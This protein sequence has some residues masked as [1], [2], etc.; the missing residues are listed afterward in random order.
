MEDQN[1]AKQRFSFKQFFSDTKTILLH[2][3]EYF[4]GMPL[5]GG[6][7]EPIVKALIYGFL[8]GVIF[9]IWTSVLNSMGIDFGVSWL[10]RYYLITAP[11]VFT[12]PAFISLFAG[13]GIML[14]ISSIFGGNTG[15]EASVRVV[16]SLMIIEVV[17]AVFIFTGV[18]NPYLSLGVNVAVSLWGLYLTYLAIMLSLKAEKGTGS[19]PERSSDVTKECR[20]LLLMSVLTSGLLILLNIYIGY[21]AVQQFKG[22]SWTFLGGFFILASWL[23]TIPLLIISLLQIRMVR[24]NNNKKR[25]FPLLFGIVTMLTGF[26]LFEV[27]DWWFLIVL[28]DLLLIISALICGRKKRSKESEEQSHSPAG[29]LQ[30][31]DGK[32]K[33]ITYKITVVFQMIGL[34]LLLLITVS[35]FFAP[36]S[37]GGKLTQDQ[38]DILAFAFGFLFLIHGTVTI[39]Y[40]KKKKWALKFKYLESYVLLGL[41]V[42]ISL[43]FLISDGISLTSAFLTTALSFSLLILLFIYLIYNY[44][45]L[46]RSGLF[47]LLITVL[48][49][50]P[51]M[52]RAQEAENTGEIPLLSKNDLNPYVEFYTTDITDFYHPEETSAYPPVN[53]FDGYFKTCWVA[54]SAN[55]NRHSVLYIRVPGEIPPEKLILNIFSGYGKSRKLYRANARPEKI[56]ISILAACNPEGYSTEVVDNYLTA[57]YPVEKQIVLADTFGVQSFPLHYSNKDLLDFQNKYLK[58]CKLSLQ[59]DTMNIRSAFILKLEITDVYGGT[60]YDDICISEI[61]LN[62]RFVTAFPDRYIQA[63]NVYIENDNMLFADYADRKGVMIYKDTL[64]EFTIV[65][66]EDHSDWAVLHYVENDEAGPGSR[67]EESY[68]LIDLKN[69]KVVNNDFEKCTGIFFY[70]PYLETDEN[71]EPFVSSRYKVMLK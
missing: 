55:E 46:M 56:K 27:I 53:L 50:A 49:M 9:V 68:L 30:H 25:L 62:N 48:F 7:T 42:L 1:K 16:A 8:I 51:D 39:A 22:E 52:L 5:N 69:R 19:R 14:G 41:T 57:K 6:F 21:M 10:G 47:L 43:A 59:G 71:G 18:I 63:D 37:S 34:A 13:G 35:F 32:A 70:A 60:D 20:F 23:V 31:T 44:K 33:N 17:R 26:M 40:M 45:K 2:P 67:I 36:P 15:Y 58:K 66:P 29:E 12:V 61:F 24:Y 54:G 65:Y 4:S 3:K 11:F 64:S 38:G 28:F